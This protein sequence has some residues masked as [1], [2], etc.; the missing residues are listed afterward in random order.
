VPTSTNALYVFDQGM[1]TGS[2]SGTGVT[3]YNL[4]NGL[5]WN[6]NVNANF[7]APTTGPTAG[8]VFYQPPSDTG[9]ITKNGK[10][11]SVDFAGGFYA[12]T[13]DFTFNGDLP[14]LTFIVAG[15]ITMNGGGMNVAGPATGSV[16]GHGVLAE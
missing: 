13:S 14:N 16:S 5:T 4:G 10:A 11:G 9:S 1:P 8:M 7:T 6:G 2:S 3:I 15:S 12:P